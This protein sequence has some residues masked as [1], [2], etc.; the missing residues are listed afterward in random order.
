M[1]APEHEAAHRINN[2]LHIHVIAL[3]SKLLHLCIFPL[4]M[5]VGGVHGFTFT[6]KLLI[7]LTADLASV[8]KDGTD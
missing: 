6:C 5:Q 3:L 7:N 4:I 2:G 8:L 1:S